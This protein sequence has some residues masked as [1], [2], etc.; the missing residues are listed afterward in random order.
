MVRTP[1]DIL[2]IVC[3]PYD[4]VVLVR[5][6][7]GIV[8]MV[9]TPYGMV[10]MVCAPDDKVIMACTPCGTTGM[11]WTP[12]I[13]LTIISTSTGIL[14][15]TWFSSKQPKLGQ[16]QELSF[17]LELVSPL[18]VTHTPPFGDLLLPLA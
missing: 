15:L 18:E 5:T 10:V 9:Y 13:T 4:M 6:S 11:P 16:T 8:V 2:V 12:M 3:T 1:Y 14:D 7:D 17:S